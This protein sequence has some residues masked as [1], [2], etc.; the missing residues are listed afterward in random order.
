MTLPRGVRVFN[1]GNAVQTRDSWVGE[2]MSSRDP[3]FMTFS[4]MQ[5][6]VRCTAKIE[7]DPLDV[8]GARDGGHPAP[9]GR[10]RQ[11]LGAD[12]GVRARDPGGC[13]RQAGHHPGRASG[14]SRRAWG[15]FRPV[16]DLE[17]LRAPQDH[18]QKKSAH[19]AEQERPDVLARRR[20]WFDA[21]WTSIPSG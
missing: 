20:T 9:A 6:G 19:A 7:R 13:G 12:R 21:N 15:L 3:R 17:V 16:D 5:F 18:A 4:S 2:V 8:A 10:R 1:P 11:A 14:A